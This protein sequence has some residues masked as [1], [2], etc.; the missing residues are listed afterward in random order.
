[1]K[2][3]TRWMVLGLCLLLPACALGVTEGTVEDAP[4]VTLDGM[5]PAKEQVSYLPDETMYAGYGD[6][7][8]S[9]ENAQAWVECER[10]ED[11]CYYDVEQ[12]PRLTAGE[13]ARAKA[14]LAKVQAGEIAYTGESVLDKME[15][16]VVGVYTIDA[17]NYG[18]EQ[19]FVLLPGPCMTDEQ[20]L[21]L[22]DAFDQLG[23]T[24][25]PDALSYRNCARGGGLECSRFLTDEERERY[26]QLAD[27]IERGLLDVARLNMPQ[28][29]QPKLDSRYYC[30]MEDFTLRPYR[31]ISDEE[32]CAMLVASGVHD[33]TGEL[34]LSALEKESRDI[35]YTRLDCPL[36][37]KL[38][39]IS[40]DGGYVP[41]LVDANGS[42]AWSGDVRKSVGT[43]FSYRNAAGIE[44]F[45]GTTF[46]R[47]TGELISASA[48]DN[49]EWELEQSE[50]AT[51][52]S[53]ETVLAAIEEAER[54]VGLE[55]LTWHLQ[56]E[57]SATNWG[58]CR[59][60][61]A[62]VEDGLWLTVYIG[63]DDGQVHG[64][65]LDRCTLVDELPQE[66]PVNG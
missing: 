18:G 15:D 57:E 42:R 36:S 29:I 48:M 10:D 21:S 59:T 1:M 51:S 58:S 20:L 17:E 12:R 56:N 49:R 64:L 47:E 13:A 35:L 50:P 32:L 22:I 19:A 55:N 53:H 9:W 3:M 8:P 31:A 60:A 43:F 11:G 41:M 66:E 25:D 27:L 65:A 38:E 26:Q 37:M 45:A 62:Q 4:M 40:Y 54:I 7:N 14:L 24:F 46:D 39:S 34:D 2:K 61:C 52:I 30:G 16:V 6:W 44:V 5:S 23:L 63:L 33:M 28:A